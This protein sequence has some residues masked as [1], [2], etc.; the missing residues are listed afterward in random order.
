[1]ALINRF[2]RLV[3]AD[4]H[5]VI[6]QFEEPMMLL[7]QS[8]REMEEVI[9]QEQKQLKQYQQQQSQTGAHRVHLETIITESSSKLETCFN[10]DNEVLARTLIRRKL[11][12][13]QRLNR[14]K[15]KQTKIGQ[16]AE[17]VQQRINDQQPKLE[18]MQQE[19]ALLNIEKPRTAT[20]SSSG[21]DWFQTAVSDADVEV[22]LLHEKAQRSAS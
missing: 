2:T 22:A 21:D 1:V 7:K 13:E 17:E 18:S 19:L 4:L 20:A 8:L 5:T 6:E 16:M 3:K 12:A 10:A 11:E 14:L 15:E 9:Q